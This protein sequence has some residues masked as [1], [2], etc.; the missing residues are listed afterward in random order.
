MMS[1]DHHVI[2]FSDGSAVCEEHFF[3][4]LVK[5][6]SCEDG[7]R[8]SIYITGIKTNDVMEFLTVDHEEAVRRLQQLSER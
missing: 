8:M 1:V 6:G 4:L 5:V 7:G 2:G 3:C